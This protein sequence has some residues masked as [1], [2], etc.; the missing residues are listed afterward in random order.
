M[1][2]QEQV[3]G[4][5]VQPEKK[6]TSRPWFLT[7]LVIILFVCVG[8]S[9]LWTA[10]LSLQVSSLSLELKTL[11]ADNRRLVQVENKLS[12][13]ELQNRLQT[14]ERS[15]ADMSRLAGV[16]QQ[17]DAKKADELL[18][19]IDGLEAEKDLLQKQLENYQEA[20]KKPL[21]N[22]PDVPSLQKMSETEPSTSEDTSSLKPTP[23]SSWWQKIINFRF[24]KRG[25]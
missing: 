4:Q 12:R 14:I 3:N 8:I 15:I 18:N 9:V 1:A 23:A 24:F 21:E 2:E 7:V 13:M 17:A 22:T 5:P 25:Q 16:F 6:N 11:R 20:I 19:V 10:K